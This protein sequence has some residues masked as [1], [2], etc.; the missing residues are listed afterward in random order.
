MVEIRQR[1]MVFAAYSLLNR[2][3]ELTYIPLELRHGLYRG[4]KKEPDFYIQINQDLMPTLAVEVGWSP[5]PSGDES[6]S[7]SPEVVVTPTPAPRSS[8]RKAVKTPAQ[9]LAAPETPM[10]PPTTM[11]TPVQTPAAAPASHCHNSITT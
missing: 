9:P 2:N 5:P 6:S 8:A 7:H 1:G 3:S 4:S 10:A 11:K